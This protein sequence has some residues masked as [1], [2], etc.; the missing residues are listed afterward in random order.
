MARTSSV[1][2]A[3]QAVQAQ[4]TEGVKAVKREKPSKKKRATKTVVLSAAALAGAYAVAKKL[5]LL[6]GS[7]PDASDKAKRATEA[8]KQAVTFDETDVP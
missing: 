5:G 4:V 1:K 3:K 8:A 2:K 7:R 6:E